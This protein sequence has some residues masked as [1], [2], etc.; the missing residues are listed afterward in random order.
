MNEN[1]YQVNQPVNNY[2]APSKLIIGGGIILLSLLFVGTIFAAYNYGLNQNTPVPSVPSPTP[3]SEIS[4]EPSPTPNVSDSS[5]FGTITWTKPLEVASPDV[6]KKTSDPNGMNYSFVSTHLVGTFSSGA[7]MLLSFIQGEGPGMAHPYRVIKHNNEYYLHDSLILEK[8]IKTELPNIFDQSKIKF[9]AYDTF[10]LLPPDS[11]VGDNQVN[12]IAAPN[13]FSAAFFPLLKNP[14]KLT[15]SKYGDFYT[16]YSTPYD[17]KDLQSR[18]IFLKLSD[19]SLIGHKLSFNFF[20]DDRV[21][22]V[23]FNQ[24][25][26]NKDQ[27]EAGIPYGC[28]IG[29]ANTIIKNT[30]SLLSDKQE[31]GYLT[32]SQDKKIYQI[33]N[34]D[35]ALVKFLY[36]QYGMGH[37]YPSAAPAMPIENFSQEP[38]HFLY[39]DD[40]GDWIVFVNNKY[41]LPVECGKPVIYLYPPEDTQ[42]SVKV[43]ADVTVSEPLYPADG[44]TVVAHPNGQLDYQGKTYPNLF[45]EGLGHGPYPNR[46]KEGTVVTQDKLVST[47][48]SQLAQ[49]GLNDQESNDFMD[50]WKDRLPTTPY[51]RLTWL[52]TADMNRLAPLQVSPAP[53]T[54]IRIFLEFEG[55]EKPVALKPQMLSSRPRLGFTLVE[56]GGLL[57]K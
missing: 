7:Q 57:R 55:L 8:Y 40:L 12:F 1:I 15:S 41:A 21:P 46:T 47:L 32:N 3:T 39:Q 10:N 31:V 22:I 35:N 44:W 36:S 52:D 33:K 4:P 16:V 5:N 53:R 20:F 56:W 24:Q 14:E 37:N 11:L 48:R 18:E 54:T 2:K 26:V 25:G 42:V 6:L 17:L 38:N 23:T 27:Y 30:N 13:G 9:I 34:K 50:F 28:G 19:S 29:S 45:W 51:V 43:A 49:L